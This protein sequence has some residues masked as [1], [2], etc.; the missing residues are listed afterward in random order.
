MGSSFV[1]DQDLLLV[2]KLPEE[3]KQAAR[4]VCLRYGAEDLL[5][6]IAIDEC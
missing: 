4:A 1:I 3:T 2:T 6:M 5:D